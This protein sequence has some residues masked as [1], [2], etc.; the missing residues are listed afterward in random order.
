MFSIFFVCDVEWHEFNECEKCETAAI[1]NS[2]HFVEYF[3]FKIF[4][5]F[6]EFSSYSNKNCEIFKNI[7]FI[8]NQLQNF[9]LQTLNNCH[10]F[11]WKEN[12]IFFF[13]KF[14]CQLNTMSCFHDYDFTL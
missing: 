5:I 8:K 10:E 9:K 3:V 14:C 7:L 2:E 4:K 12:F 13:D 1:Q 11:P 6:N